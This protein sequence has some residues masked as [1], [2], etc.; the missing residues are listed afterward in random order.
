MKEKTAVYICLKTLK[1][2]LGVSIILCIEGITVVKAWAKQ[3]PV[4]E[5]SLNLIL[6]TID[7]LRADHLGCYGYEDINTPV[8]DQLASNGVLFTRHYSPVPIT[9]PSH[10][11]I[12]TG[13]YPPAHGVHNNGT[14]VLSDEALTLAEILKKEKYHTAA[15]VGAYVLH[16]RYGLHQGFDVY[17]DHFP[18]SQDSAL[19]LYNERPAGKVMDM[20][21]EW[22]EEKRED[23]FFLWIHLFDPH[24]P[25]A[26]P[27]PFRESYKLHPYDGEI[28]YIDSQISRLVKKLNSLNLGSKTL[29]LLTSDH[30]EGLDEHGEKTHAVFIYDST[31]HIPLILYLPGLL[32]AERKITEMVFSVDILPTILDIL[33]IPAVSRSAHL[34]GYSLLGLI[35]GD[36]KINERNFYCESHYPE[37]N[38]GWSCL[39][40]IKTKKWKFIEAPRSE[41][42]RIDHDPKELNNLFEKEKAVAE[43]LRKELHTLKKELLS[44]DENLTHTVSL[45]NETRQRLESLGYVWT[46]PSGDEEQGN[47]PDPKDMIKTLEDLDVAMFYSLLGLYN[48]AI[49]YLERVVKNNPANFKAHFYLASN[50]EKAGEYDKAIAAYQRVISMD[51]GYSEAHNSLGAVLEKKGQLDLALKQ[52]LL[53]EELSGNYMEVYHNLGVVYDRKGEYEK[54]LMYL[55]KAVEFVPDHPSVRNNLGG[56]LLKLGRHYEALREFKRVI[57]LEPQKIEA[58]NNLGIAYRTVGENE[59]AERYFKKAI[60]IDPN[61]PGTYSNLAGFYIANKRYDEAIVMARKALYY[62]D[63]WM[64]AYMNLGIAHFYLDQFKEAIPFLEKAASIDDEQAEAFTSLGLCYFYLRDYDKAKYYYQKTLALDSQNIKARINMGTIL[65]KEDKIQKA[66]EEWENCLKLDSD[67][68]ETYVNLGTAYLK[69]EGY[70]DAVKNWKQVLRLNPNHVTAYLNLGNCY[71]QMGLINLAISQWSK[72]VSLDDSS[73]AAHTNLASAYYKQGRMELALLEWRKVDDLDPY[74]AEAAYNQGLIY[75]NKGDYKQAMDH[76]A[77]V[78]RLDPSHSYAQVLLNQVKKLKKND[79]S[80]LKNN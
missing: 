14:C 9:L 36:K 61:Y 55:L 49:E 65:F 15:F 18:P 39:E 80:T 44:E 32:P 21:L 62:D 7:T 13:L 60:E 54:A 11:T 28:A 73:I 16:S 70:D 63:Q 42:Y 35:K 43:G 46:K 52:L 50:Y 47:L 41:L 66:I 76:L 69:L 59:M 75:L 25:Y 67:S 74:N 1:I 20:S 5:K 33:E 23:K 4:E 72:A 27:E 78:L 64:D 17:N 12:M 56:V 71:Y 37:L 45:D 19:P 48:K 29:L 6:I 3:K 31:L 58:Y 38:F 79:T 2:L 24:A 57:D 51:P 53:A 68:I 30:G 34:Q 8:I 26:P 40:G 22:L 77:R 10:V